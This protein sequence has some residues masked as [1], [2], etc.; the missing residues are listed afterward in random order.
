MDKEREKESLGI[1]MESIKLE[2]VIHDFL[3]KHDKSSASI[4][5]YERAKKVKEWLNDY[6]ERCNSEG[7][8]IPGDELVNKCHGYIRTL[9]R[10]AERMEKIPTV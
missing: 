7:L 5:M 1:L 6:K 8:E 10:A 2:M 9:E 3:N 4:F